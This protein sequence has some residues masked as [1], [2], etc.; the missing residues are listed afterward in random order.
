MFDM[1][2]IAIQ[3]VEATLHGESPVTEA[4]TVEKGQKKL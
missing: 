2:S 1:D 4:T 3:D